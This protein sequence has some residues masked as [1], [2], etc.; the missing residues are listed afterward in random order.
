[1]VASEVLLVALAEL[2]G[3]PEET[4]T[5]AEEW[6]ITEE[7]VHHAVHLLEHRAS[8]EGIHDPYPLR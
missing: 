8:S 7:A 4:G 2:G 6:V 3:G 5:A 1:V